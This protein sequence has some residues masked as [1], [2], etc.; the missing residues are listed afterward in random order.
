MWKEFI[1]LIN[2]ITLLL[3]AFFASATTPVNTLNKRFKKI[4]YPNNKDFTARITI[5]DDILLIF[6]YRP[7]AF[8]LL[9]Y[10]PQGIWFLFSSVVEGLNVTQA[11][12][13]DA[14]LIG[15]NGGLKWPYI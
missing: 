4:D 13:L 14:G 15:D 3:C 1:V 10:K 11:A 5:L 9:A 6:G 12:I 7:D 2:M 8:V